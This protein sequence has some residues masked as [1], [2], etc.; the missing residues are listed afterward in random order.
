M[1]GV[2]T[3][4]LPISD[5]IS[6]LGQLLKEEKS[7][8]SPLVADKNV[9]TVVET[10][11]SEKGWT[12]IGLGDS[13]KAADLNTIMKAISNDNGASEITLYEIPNL[14]LF[15]YG[16]NTNNQEQYFMNYNQFSMREAVSIQNFYPVLKEDA[17]RFNKNF[18]DQIKKAKLV[19]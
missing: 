2:Q 18:G 13:Q 3:C 17:M 16:V 10:A 7:F 4:A 11:K 6:S 9:T 5:S 12:V 8:I 19:K 15:I 1:T 14:Q